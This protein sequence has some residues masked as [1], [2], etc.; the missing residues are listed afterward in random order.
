[1]TIELTTIERDLLARVVEERHR[2]LERE[3][4]RTDHH[5]FK[6]LLREEQKALEQLLARLGAKLSEA[7]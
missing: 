2:Q 7:V 1:M 6:D 4:W 5:H 3:L